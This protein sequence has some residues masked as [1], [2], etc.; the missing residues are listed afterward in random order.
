MFRKFWTAASLSLLF[1]MIAAIQKTSGRPVPPSTPV[2]KTIIIDAG[3]GLPD[4]GAE[5]SN[6][7]ESQIS[8][9]IAL[10]LGKKLEEV[11]PDCKIVYT[12][13]NENLPQG[14]MNKNEANRLR[15]KIANENRGDLFISIHLNSAADRYSKKI[16][17]YKKET[18]YTY[19][20]KGK[21]RKKVAKT[22]SVP[23][24]KYY[25]LPCNVSGTETYIWAVNKNDLKKQFVGSNEED[26][27]GEQADS[28]YSYFDSPEAMILASLR[29]KKYFDNS[30]LIAGLVEEEF[31]KQ[32]RNSR[33]VKQRNNE[34]IWVLQATAMPS[35][36][37]ETGFICDPDEEAYLNSEKGQ[38]EVSY[39]V[40]NAILRYKQT[41]EN[42]AIKLTETNTQQ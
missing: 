34:A 17:G 11:L 29:T 41:I 3:H 10:K 32:G 5:G 14:L 1:S 4:P 35:I 26:M 22:R 33:G 20:G 6:S 15:A 39:A 42:P 8:L 13:T 37:V 2:L 18:Y 31:I 12:R 7:T 40:M 19:T 27:F 16:T 24:Y 21:S 23:I 30:R 25:R 28:S 38:D 36:L 9:A